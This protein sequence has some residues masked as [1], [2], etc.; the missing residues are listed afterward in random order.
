MLFCVV[1]VLMV[2]DAVVTWF[3]GWVTGLIAWCACI[4]LVDRIPSRARTVIGA[5]TAAGV[6][7]IAIGMASGETGLVKAGIEQNVPLIGMI[8]A[9]SALRLL[10]VAPDADERAQARGPR[11]LAR[12]IAGVHLFGAVINFP[13]VIIFADRL[14]AKTKITLEQTMALTQ[15]FTIGAIW[16][17]FYGA[18]AVALTVSPGASL[19]TLMAVGIPLTAVGLAI[20]WFML[21]SA[22]HR[23]ARDFDGYPI[24]FD[25]LWVPG[26]LAASVLMI[27][28][29]RPEWPILP[30]IA[31]LSPIVALFTLLVRDGMRAFEAFGRLITMRLPE[32]GNE[33]GLF[34]G[35]GILSAGMAGVI[36]ALDL[37]V[38]F[39]R[40]GGVEASAVLV[41]IVVMSWLGFHPVILVSVIGP[42]VQTIHPDPN[43]LAMTFLMTWGMGL[44]ACP[45]SGTLVAM[46]GRYNIPYRAVLDRNR[47][48]AA[49]LMVAGVVVLNLYAALVMPR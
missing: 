3:P 18:M 2:F 27:H 21:T 23:H 36:A 35:A 28:H 37:S 30:V 38:P 20:T 7:G 25:T 45:M 9:V 43:L 1:V 6:V 16:S 14:T 39:T 26:L 11:A 48:Y 17:P 41:F 29:L 5:L 49:K 24:R 32:L 40:F 44:P 31:V 33:I 13:A 8:I 12:T 47:V 4:L 10:G 42:W 34:L 19:G 46:S 15:P 22:R